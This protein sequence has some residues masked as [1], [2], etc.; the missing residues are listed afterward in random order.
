MKF[1]VI[2]PVYNMAQLLPRCLDSLINQTYADIEIILIDD[3]STDNSGKI[4]DDYSK[5]DDRIIVIHQKN[6]GVSAARNTGLDK[7]SGDY[8]SFVDP[9]DWVVPEMYDTLAKYVADKKIDILRFNAYRKDEVINPLPFRNEYKDKLLDEKIMLPLIGAE[10]FGGMF[11]LGVLWLHIFKREIIEEH[12]IC[13]NK[14]LRRCE[15]RLFT[16]TALLHSKNIVFIDSILYHY[17]VNEGSLSNKYDPLR[18]EQEITYLAELKKEYSKCKPKEFT[19]K[20]DIRIKSEY[21]LRAV[22]SVNNEFFSDNKNGFISKYRNTKDIINNTNVKKAVKEV[23][24]NKSGLKGIITLGL[25]RFRLSL[26]L[27]LFNT[28]LLYKNKIKKHG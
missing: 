13:F 24:A 1:S 26:L 12:N 17:E 27:S 14:K 21:L 8:L 5:K 11:I 25:I 22:T 2:I 6:A 9:D 15:D 3:G 7:A 18:W 20:A 16:L 4:C 19:E 23:P 10:T 28:A